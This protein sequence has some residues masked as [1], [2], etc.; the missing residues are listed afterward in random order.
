MKIL[1]V[2]I[3]FV[4]TTSSSPV[5]SRDGIRDPDFQN[6]QFFH[7][8]QMILFEQE[9]GKTPTD[10]SKE[11]QVPFVNQFYTS[12]TS[13]P[14]LFPSA[15]ESEVEDQ[16]NKLLRIILNIFILFVMPPIVVLG[17]I[18]YLQHKVHQRHN[19][20]LVHNRYTFVSRVRYTKVWHEGEGD[21]H[22]PLIELDAA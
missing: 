7:Y 2:L 10:R 18:V 9:R 4:A 11:E 16:S 21:E 5:L 17:I 6:R 13:S 19:D 3:F 1:F 12:T 8:P 20:D 14:Q 15:S 22:D